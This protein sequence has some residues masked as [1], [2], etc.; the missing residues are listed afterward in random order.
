MVGIV[1][2][3]DGQIFKERELCLWLTLSQTLKQDLEVFSTHI[4]RIFCPPE[5]H[6]APKGLRRDSVSLPKPTPGHSVLRTSP[7]M[8]WT[9]PDLHLWGV[10]VFALQRWSSRTTKHTSKA[11][12]PAHRAG[13]SPGMPSDIPHIP[14][15][16]CC[17]PSWKPVFILLSHS[18]LPKHPAQDLC[19]Y[20]LWVSV[21]MGESSGS[22][23]S[24]L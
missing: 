9:C 3:L 21:R 22:T 4:S 2:A 15:W 16:C 5:A 13:T 23:W 14:S 12:Y 6:H 10:S 8:R 1:Y 24:S 19:P 11:T 18:L 17:L 20:P 7:F